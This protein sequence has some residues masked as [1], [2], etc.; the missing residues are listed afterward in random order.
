MFSIGAILSPYLSEWLR[1]EYV[2]DVPYKQEHVV[3]NFI[4]LLIIL[5]SKQQWWTSGG[6]N[7]QEKMETEER[8]SLHLYTHVSR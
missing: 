1:L 2:S 5:N 4:G 3:E 7:G 6:G 8:Y